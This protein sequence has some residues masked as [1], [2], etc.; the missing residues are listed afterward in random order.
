MTSPFALIMRADIAGPTSTLG[1]RYRPR[2]NF[3]SGYGATSSRNITQSYHP[4]SQIQL[5]S[6]V[7]PIIMASGVLPL[8]LKISCAV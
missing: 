5:I 6:G 8:S 1:P 4:N 2:T 7:S 3:G